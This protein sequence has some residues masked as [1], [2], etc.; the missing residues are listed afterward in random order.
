M[1]CE[2]GKLHKHKKIIIIISIIRTY[3]RIRS[4]R[5]NINIFAMEKISNI[6]ELYTSFHSWWWWSS[7]FFSLE[8]FNIEPK[9]IKYKRWVSKAIIEKFRWLS[10]YTFGSASNKKLLRNF[11]IF[12]SLKLFSLIILVFKWTWKKKLIETKSYR[13][14]KNSSESVCQKKTDVSSSN[15]F[16]F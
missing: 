4:K 8:K 10:T 12:F 5:A 9:Q 11:L 6:R 15:R 1:K 16:I 7:I 14:R 3:D 13:S 2:W